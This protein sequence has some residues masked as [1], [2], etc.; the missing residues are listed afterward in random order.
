MKLLIC[1]GLGEPRF[2]SNKGLIHAFKK[3]GVETWVI[4]PKYWDRGEEEANVLFEDRPYPELWT[5][6]EVLDVCPWTPD[7]IFQISP[8][9]WL[10]GDKPKD[11]K[12]GFYSTDT[13]ADGAMFRQGAIWGQFDYLF[14]CP[15][16]YVH[17]FRDLAPNVHLLLP[18]FDER[19]FRKDVNIEPECDIAFVGQSGLRLDFNN[20]HIKHFAKMDDVGCYID[21]VHEILPDGLDKYSSSGPS[22]DYSERGELLYRLSKHFDVRIYEPLWDERLQLAIQKGRIGFNHSLLHD[23]SIRV[24]E[25]L[26]SARIPVVDYNFSVETND[27]IIIGREW[28]FA[29][30]YSGGLYRPFYPN[31][32]L[33]YDHV[34][35]MVTETLETKTNKEHQEQARDWA[36]EHSTWTHRAQQILSCVGL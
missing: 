6:K 11:I 15:P 21:N 34:K 31:F 4:G 24:W 22:Y 16:A 26:A 1:T 13:H 5:Y 33:I 12:S 32:S 27:Q 29:E 10:Y 30:M 23:L 2:S 35:K 18:A 9:F 20:P 14:V 25:I 36:F 3:L 8:H 7:F 19:R 17:F 28:L